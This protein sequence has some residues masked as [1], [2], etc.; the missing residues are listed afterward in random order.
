MSDLTVATALGMQQA[1]LGKDATMMMLKQVIQQEQAVLQVV[2][3]ATQT[4]PA[5]STQP[6]LGQH[7]N[8]TV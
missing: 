4:T 3:A 2:Q 5:A 6:Y 1:S 8:L 7:L